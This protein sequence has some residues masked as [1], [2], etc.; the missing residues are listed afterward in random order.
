MRARNDWAPVF[1]MFICTR[2]LNKFLRW[3]HTRF[4]KERLQLTDEEI[5]FGIQDKQHALLNHCGV[6][7]K[8][9]LYLCRSLEILPSFNLFLIKLNQTYHTEKYICYKD[10]SM[11]RFRKKWNV[12]ELGWYSN[13]F[14]LFLSLFCFYASV[15]K[16]PEALCFRVVRTSVRP[17]P[18]VCTSRSRDHVI[19]RKI[20]MDSC[21]T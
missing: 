7:A 10:V 12:L 15:T 13:L 17:V 8:K 20:L 1:R 19:S 5:L 16:Y 11:H 9:T 6:I 14:M 3:W 18:Y 4:N 2:D 21:Q